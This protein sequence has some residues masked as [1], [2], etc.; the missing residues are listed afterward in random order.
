MIIKAPYIIDR[1][2]AHGST[3]TQAQC[4]DNVTSSGFSL[5]VGVLHRLNMRKTI[6]TSNM[7]SSETLNPEILNPKP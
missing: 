1:V 6:Q 4:L 7:R 5:V 2:A 3:G